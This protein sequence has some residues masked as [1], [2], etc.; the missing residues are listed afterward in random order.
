M[1]SDNNSTIRLIKSRANSP[2]RR[3]IYLDYHYIQDT[4]DRGEV[5]VNYMASIDMVVGPLTKGTVWN[6]MPSPPDAQVTSL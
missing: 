5:T 2:K 4:G 3:H 1:Y 6:Y